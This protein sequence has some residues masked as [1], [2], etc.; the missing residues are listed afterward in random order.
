MDLHKKIAPGDYRLVIYAGS[1]SGQKQ[2][3]VRFN[4]KPVPQS[5]VQDKTYVLK[6]SHKSNVTVQVIEKQ[7]HLAEPVVLPQLYITPEEGT[8]VLYGLTLKMTSAE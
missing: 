7:I 3:K 8:V 4:T 2:V 1:A 5:N 6:N